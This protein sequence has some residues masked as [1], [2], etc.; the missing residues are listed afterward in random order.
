MSGR[1]GEGGN[2]L[3]KRLDKLTITHLL[4]DEFFHS[5]S[6]VHKLTFLGV[7]LPLQVTNTAGQ[8]R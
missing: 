4:F 1:K 5:L 8:I 3:L 2:P 7:V 6:R